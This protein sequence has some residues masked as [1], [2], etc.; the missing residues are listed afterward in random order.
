MGAK[1]GKIFCKRSLMVKMAN[2][3]SLIEERE[4]LFYSLKR[5]LNALFTL[6]ISLPIKFP[7][8][9]ML[10]SLLTLYWKM[11][12]RLHRGISK[13]RRELLDWKHIRGLQ[14]R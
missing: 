10:L 7:A 9:T 1:S 12:L 6:R 5:N 13:E 14:P 11:R 3:T 8:L 4:V 2:G